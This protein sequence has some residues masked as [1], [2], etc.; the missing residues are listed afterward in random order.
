M[1]GW[2]RRC[3]CLP[4]VG[5][6]QPTRLTCGNR[7]VAGS[8]PARPTKL[9]SPKW[10]WLRLILRQKPHSGLFDFEN[11]ARRAGLHFKVWSRP[12]FF[13]D[14]IQVISARYIENSMKRKLKVP[15]AHT[16]CE[17]GF[18]TSLINPRRNSKFRTK[19]GVANMDGSKNSYENQVQAYKQKL[20]KYE[21][22]IKE[23]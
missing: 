16:I 4:M 9:L 13:D 15:I 23:K 20:T 14:D 7:T 19:V 2:R 3:R 1:F 6:T 17:L 22:V 11:L 12:V 18:L 21:S 8:N 10:G 5:V